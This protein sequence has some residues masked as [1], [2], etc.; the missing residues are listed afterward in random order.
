MENNNIL[1]IAYAVLLLMG[2]LLLCFV[3]YSLIFSR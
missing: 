2:A 3:L 1:L